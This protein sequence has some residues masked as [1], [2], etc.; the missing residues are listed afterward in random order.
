M[1]D[2]DDDIYYIFKFIE[3]MRFNKKKTKTKNSRVRQ[4]LSILFIED[5]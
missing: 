3:V 1:N 5:G 2:S 4:C